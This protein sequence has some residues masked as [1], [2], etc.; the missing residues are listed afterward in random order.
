MDNLL[1]VKQVAVKLGCSSRTVYRLSD[2]GRMPHPLKVG[3]L[4]RWRTGDIEEWISTGCPDC[5][6][7]RQPMGARS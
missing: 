2:G 5:R 7:A 4:V 3:G 6:A 1:T